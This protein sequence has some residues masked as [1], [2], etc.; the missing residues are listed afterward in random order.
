MSV[1]PSTTTT[2]TGSAPAIQ[3][4]GSGNASVFKTTGTIQ[5]VG[6]KN[7]TTNLILTGTGHKVA[8]STTLG[9]GNTGVIS[10]AKTSLPNVSSS[11]TLVSVRGSS[12]TGIRA[13]TAV[14][15]TI[16][17]VPRIS[18]EVIKSSATVLQPATHRAP[19][20]TIT[21][22]SN[23][24]GVEKHYVK[25]VQGTG[26][27]GAR[28]VSAPP[29]GQIHIAARTVAPAAVTTSTVSASSSSARIEVSAI[30]TNTG[31]TPVVYASGLKNITPITTVTNVGKV[32]HLFYYN[33]YFDERQ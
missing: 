2:A 12:T 33:A 18:G 24:Q 32:L 19:S 31:A 7:T 8:G 10:Q 3:T 22:T 16:A 30:T 23:V 29:A 27:A 1:T 6:G 5:A 13:P 21:S 25:T 9:A 17:A 11:I 26:P 28:T 4:I 14:S 15:S 20:M